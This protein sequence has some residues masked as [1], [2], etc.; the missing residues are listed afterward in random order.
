MHCALIDS[1]L[2]IS[3]ASNGWR[4]WLAAVAFRRGVEADMKL[5]IAGATGGIDRYW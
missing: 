1:I 4:R 3:N 2:F 5:T